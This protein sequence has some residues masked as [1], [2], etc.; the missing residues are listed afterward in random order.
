MTTDSLD[1][2]AKRIER[3]N[4]SRK[5]AESILLLA[6]FTVKHVWEL[7]NGYWP[8][9]PDYDDA[10]TPWWLFLTEIGPVQIGWRKRVLH[11][12]WSTCAVRSIV[13]TD[14]VTKTFTY[15]HAYRVEKAVEYL[16]NLRQIATSASTG[17]HHPT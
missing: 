12:E 2:A 3:R 17:C 10:R 9:S 6:G 5:E 1:I 11:I 7:A 16:R 4:A 15:V 8:D 13:T 14:D